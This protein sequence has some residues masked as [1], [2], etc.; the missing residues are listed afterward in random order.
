[1]VKS[2]ATEAPVVTRAWARARILDLESRWAGGE[3]LEKEIVCVSLHYGVLSRFTGFVSIDREGEVVGPLHRVTQP[4]ESPAGWGQS[5]ACQAALFQMEATDQRQ[6]QSIYTQVAAEAQKQRTERWK[7]MA[8]SQTKIFEITRDATLNRAKIFDKAFLQ[9]T[10]YLDADPSKPMGAPTPLRE[11]LKKAIGFLTTGV[12][13]VERFQEW[14]RAISHHLADLARRLGSLYQDT[15]YVECNAAE[16]E[17]AL[18]GIETIERAMESLWE[19]TETRERAQL[20]R[21]VERLRE[22][23]A[24]LLEGIRANRRFRARLEQE[25]GYE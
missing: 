4:V 23:E 24:R 3:D 10:R 8:D 17:L 5:V 7:I 2:V 12:W 6:A 22:G 13:T 21:G 11:Q 20:D 14:I 16:V 25:W 15:S 1:M 18:S 19:Y 9:A